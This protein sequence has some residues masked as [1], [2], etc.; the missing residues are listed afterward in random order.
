MRVVHRHGPGPLKTFGTSRVALAAATVLP[1][2]PL[3][4]FA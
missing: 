3:G 4:V 1:L 2:V